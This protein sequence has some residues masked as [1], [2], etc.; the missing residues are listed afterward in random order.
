MEEAE[1]EGDPVGRSAVSTNLEPRDLSDTEPPNRHHTPADMR[2]P[3]THIYS[4]GL[5]GLALE[6]EDAPN[7]LE[8]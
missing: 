7:F 5:L 6:R 1:E 2:P 3:H 4:G 8:T